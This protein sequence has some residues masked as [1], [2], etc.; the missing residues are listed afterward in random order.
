[1]EK[2]DAIIIGSGKGGKVLAGQLAGRSEKVA[3]I[4]KSDTMYGG[5]CPSV[6]CVPTKFLVNRA[7]EAR[8]FAFPTFE[9]KAAFYAKAIEAKKALRAKLNAKMFA[10]FSSN[11]NIDLITGTAEFTGPH[12]VIVRGGDFT[13]ELSSDK[14][15]IDTGSK[16][17]IPDIEGL[18]A[19]KKVY[20]STEM[21]ELD[22]LPRDLV[23]I[24]GGN[25]GLEFASIYSRFGA[26][27]TVLQDL[28]EF[29]PNEDA[30][31]A[32]CVK[33][34]LLAQGI[35]FHFGV[36]VL[37]L[38][39]TGE[40]TTVAYLADGREYSAAADAVLIST[41]RVPNTDG[42]GL[43]A[44]GVAQTPRGAVAVDERMRTNVT[45]VWAI[46]DVTGGAQF[47]YISQDDARIVLS[48]MTDGVRTN[49]GRNIPYSVFLSPTL[50]RVGL[51]EKAARA[52]NIEVKTA[53]LLPTSLPRAHA[54]ERYTGM[55]KA[56]VDANSGLILGVSLFCDES[57][58][59]I[60]IVTLA[61][62]ENIK[63]TALRDMI[64]THPVMSEAMN[65]LF[66][67]VK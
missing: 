57:H 61:M 3:L 32:S 23:I 17:F 54:M 46:G 22:K 21:L 24:G 6:G 58:E 31:I 65:D 43:D 48:D 4:E 29:M 9:E 12:S 28:A 26:N 33:E 40:K 42:L 62:N 18:A 27:V 15:I 2:F 37:S 11:P 1:M 56:V 50:S 59:M 66:G 25:I 35:K 52:K 16:P 49:V 55:L 10:A 19:A 63:Y 14:I 44:A 41:G 67:G 7:D 47:T 13:R 5:T 20:T 51:T 53:T 45:G 34:A 30:E 64:F 60:N 38:R 8:L 39:T 36:K